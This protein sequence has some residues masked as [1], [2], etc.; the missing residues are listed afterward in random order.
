MFCLSFGTLKPGWSSWNM[1]A[2]EKKCLYSVGLVQMKL[3]VHCFLHLNYS[4]F[5]LNFFLEK[6]CKLPKTCFSIWENWCWIMRIET[7]NLSVESQF[8]IINT[9]KNPGLTLS[10]GCQLTSTLE[11]Y[12]R[13]TCKHSILQISHVDTFPLFHCTYDQ[14]PS[15]KRKRG[16][17]STPHQK[18]T[19]NSTP[20]TPCTPAVSKQAILSTPSPSVL[21]G[22]FAKKMSSS[23]S[24][25][26]VSL[27]RFQMNSSPV[28]KASTADGEGVGTYTHERLE[29]LKED[30]R[31]WVY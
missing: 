20:S 27:A 10:W 30:K 21:S 18:K 6:F 1:E 16:S 12:C 11:G 17:T 19:K 31:K 24:K 3:C 25:A 7:W 26:A 5:E 15:R 8:S 13:S 9:F 4:T 22:S 2:V 29:W 14:Q 23:A 28:P